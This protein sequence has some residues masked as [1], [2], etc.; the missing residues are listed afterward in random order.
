MTS[1]NQLIRAHVSKLEFLRNTS[2]KVMQEFA[3]ELG[4]GKDNESILNAIVELKQ[5]VIKLEARSVNL[6]SLPILGSNTE[7]YQGFAAGARSMRKDCIGAINA[8]GIGAK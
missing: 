4:C 7:W 1:V 3:D 6:P 2:S 8:A 5:Q